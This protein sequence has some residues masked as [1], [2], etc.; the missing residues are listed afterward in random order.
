M[1]GLRRAAAAAAVLLIILAMPVTA[2]ADGSWGGETDNGSR[3]WYI[4]DYAVDLNADDSASNGSSRYYKHWEYW[5]QGAS[6]YRYKADGSDGPFR[7]GC[8]IIALSKMLVETGI[9]PDNVNK[10]NP[11]IFFRWGLGPYFNE[12][13]GY[14][15]GS[16]AEA[17]ARSRG[18]E[19]VKEGRVTLS[20]R[21][22]DS[23]CRL[24][25]EKL[26]EGYY[27]ILNC[28]SHHEYVGRDASF[29]AGEVIILD[30]WGSCSRN[31]CL[32]KTFKGSAERMY[33]FDY[34]SVS[35]VKGT[36]LRRAD[37]DGE[38]K[39]SD[40][41]GLVCSLEERPMEIYPY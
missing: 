11:D 20:G 10:F 39:E 41:E 19:L 38:T 1:T 25:M 15:M 17:Y 22:S 3:I 23:D 8:L 18:C 7:S 2:F 40:W 6:A 29:Q 21:N 26:A 16:P 9:A 5:T 37:P 13:D 30:S 36:L 24:I 14:V 35:G 31:T 32:C 4:D 33:N 34:Y 12:D 27:V 28:D